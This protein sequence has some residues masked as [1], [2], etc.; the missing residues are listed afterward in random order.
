[1]ADGTTRNQHIASRNA[2]VNLVTNPATGVS[3]PRE[4][5][6]LFL[7]MP[8]LVSDDASNYRTI[9]MNL[10]N[11]R[12]AQVRTALKKIRTEIRATQDRYTKE[13]I[14]I[15][16]E[17]NSR[18]IPFVENKETIK[19][20][21]TEA[22]Y[23]KISTSS[24]MVRKQL[25]EAKQQQAAQQVDAITKML[26][27]YDNNREQAFD[28]EWIMVDEAEDTSYTQ[29]TTQEREFLIRHETKL[30][31]D[32][33]SFYNKYKLDRLSAKE[34]Y[35]LIKDHNRKRLNSI[36]RGVAGTGMTVTMLTLIGLLGHSYLK[37]HEEMEGFKQLAIRLIIKEMRK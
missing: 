21:E 22:D 27:E 15:E 36:L 20:E 19:D 26:E 13:V 8:P 23:A 32:A 3:R 17:E 9:C 37:T 34:R 4:D 1:M 10:F 18:I 28:E 35:D 12:D 14:Q 24:T 31:E 5:N 16:S 6:S 25:F 11:E 30:I 29:L 2:A 33:N 7:D